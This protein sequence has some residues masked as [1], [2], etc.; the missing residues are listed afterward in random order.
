[1]SALLSIDKLVKRFGGLTATDHVDF[2]VAPGEVHAIIGPNGAGKTTLISQLAG[3]LHPDEGSIHFDGRDI[4]R[5]T[6]PERSLLGLGRSYQISQIFRDFTALQNVML[7]VQAHAGHSFSFFRPALREAALL[8]PARAALTQVGLANRMHVPAAAMAHGEHRQL[9]LAMTLAISPKLL[10]LDE[11]MAG[12]SQ[13]ES[14]EMVQL[15]KGL[16]GQ[17][18]IVLVEHDMDAVFAL[19][20]RVSVLVYGRII[21]CGTPDEIRN[22]PDVK[23]A[24]LGDQEEAV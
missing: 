16:K 15:L 19:A 21:A 14:E 11:P 8:E 9:E 20:D 1:M 3:E 12:M 6:V 2:A 13:A 18:G 7:A 5:A 23:D 17:Y 22:N 4:S 24:Y 10:L